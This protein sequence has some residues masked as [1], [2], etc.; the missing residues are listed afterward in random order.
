MDPEDDRRMDY[1][2]VDGESHGS[3]LSAD[4]ISSF[5]HVSL[6]QDIIPEAVINNDSIEDCGSVPMN[7]ES[8][9]LE[10]V[11][12]EESSPNQVVRHRLLHVVGASMLVVAA[13]VGLASV[14]HQSI[15]PAK[16][17][18]SQDSID[19]N[20]YGS[21]EEAKD[22][23]PRMSNWYR[24]ISEEMDE[25]RMMKR[26]KKRNPLRVNPKI[27]EKTNVQNSLE[28]FKNIPV[29]NALD[30]KVPGIHEGTA[31]VDALI[32][33]ESVLEFVINATDARDECAGLTK[34]FDT[35]CSSKSASSTSGGTESQT[36]R[37]LTEKLR[38]KQGRSWDL[39]WKTTNSL[40]SFYKRYLKPSPDF[41]YIE[42]EIAGDAWDIAS[43]Q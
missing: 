18:T 3:S 38:E 42:N 22:D 7:H 29:V 13:V 16:G 37:T 11:V 14:R 2:D 31:V 20:N 36:R 23:Q 32:C 21:P 27:Q 40:H 30:D 17:G 34:A 8:S 6:A 4:P 12:E 15:F 28:K 10:L 24:R 43:H 1:A 26:K 19:R 35:T 5:S 25:H 9:N 39:A 33:R 41:L